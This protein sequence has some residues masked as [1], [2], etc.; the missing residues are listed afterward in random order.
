[1]IFNELK[2]SK[3]I[4]LYISTDQT[5]IGR[6][7]Q[8]RS[9]YAT[10]TNVINI[11]KT[12][13]DRD[14]GAYIE[15]QAIKTLLKILEVKELNEMKFF[16]RIFLFNNSL[17]IEVTGGLSDAGLVS[18]SL[19]FKNN[20]FNLE[21]YLLS[22]GQNN[23]NNYVLLFDFA[24]ATMSIKNKEEIEILDIKPLEFYASEI[25][26]EANKD[27]EITVMEYL[28]SGLSVNSIAKVTLK[29]KN[30]KDHI[31]RNYLNSLNICPLSGEEKNKGLYYQIPI[32]YVLASNTDE[33]LKTILKRFS[34]G[35]EA[36]VLKV[37]N[38]DVSSK[39]LIY[40]GVPG[41]G[42]SYSIRE[43]Y[44]LRD[45][46]HLTVT[47]HPEYSYYDFVGS[48]SPVIHNQQMFY[49][50]VPGP[51]TI[52]LDKAIKNKNE[53]YF[54]IIEEINRANASS[55]FGDLFQLLDRDDYGNSEY[56][57]YN[58][59]ISNYIYDNASTKIAIPKNLSI[60]CTMNT[61]DQNV[62]TLDTA[63]KRRFDFK[64]IKISEDDF[65]KNDFVV[66]FGSYSGETKGI[67]W[68]N[69]ALTFNKY[70]LNRI[71]KELYA[72]E[73]KQLG[74]WFIKKSDA[75]ESTIFVEKVLR[76]I[77]D[78]VVKHEKSLIFNTNSFDEILDEFAKDEVDLEKVFDKEF[79]RLLWQE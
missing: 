40:Y 27:L 66:F 78:D 46:N 60:I 16:K 31:I 33:R 17:D 55:V 50:F 35:Q 49:E 65:I 38:Q 48:I 2:T 70:L 6:Q 19:W 51:F 44:I 18:F 61:S 9:N 4:T 5:I 52:M 7:L 58:K 62:F 73:D 22:Q 67:T 13:Y 15:N 1:M 72:N 30:D 8:S 25:A 34:E 42:K 59:D 45:S 10:T 53:N 79:A 23:I 11:A 71:A 26:Y 68:S 36:D 76:Y 69:F 14:K 24:N 41:S 64:Y 29:E 37:I 43:D 63:F 77:W 20:N 54:L 56:S 21:E 57:I 39:N 75:Y 3:K 74:P 32:E 47:F 28:F 12:T